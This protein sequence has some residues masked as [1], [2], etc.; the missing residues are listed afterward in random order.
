MGRSIYHGRGRGNGH[1]NRRE[2][3]CAGCYMD[4]RTH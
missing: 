4:S 2:G 1:E 3:R